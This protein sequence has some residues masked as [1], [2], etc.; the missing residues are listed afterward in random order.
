MGIDRDLRDRAEAA[1]LQR[2]NPAPG[3]F[4]PSADDYA[5]A[6]HEL[7][8]HRVE[9]EMQNDEM[10]RIE[11][12][13]VKSRDRYF[14]L[15]DLAP[16]GFITVGEQGRIL[17]A[18]SSAT[19]MLG[20]EKAA[21]I[22][23]PLT[24]FIYREDQDGYYLFRKG[25]FEAG[26]SRHCE[27]RLV[28]KDGGIFWVRIL[29]A[30]I[31][32]PLGT[33]ELLLTIGDITERKLGEEVLLKAHRANKT[34]LAEL[35]HRAKNSFSLISGLINIAAGF[36][37]EPESRKNLE[38]LVLLVQS[39]A[40]LYDLLNSSGSISE[41]R[42]DGFCARVIT[43]LARLHGSIRLETD[44]AELTLPFKTATPIGLIL[45]EL[46]TNAMKHGFPEGRKGSIRVELKSR[47]GGATLSVMDDGVGLAPDYDSRIKPGMG[48]SLIKSLTEQLGGSF[49]IETD[50]GTRCWL[51]FPILPPETPTRRTVLLVEDDALIAAAGSMVLDEFGYDVVV[52]DNGEMA[53]K[54]ATEGPRISLVLMDI[55]LG[56]GMDGLDAAAI[57]LGRRRLPLIFLSANAE[58]DVVER[59]RRISPYGYVVKNSGDFVLQTSIEMAFKLFEA[60]GRI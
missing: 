30:Q 5:I 47:K 57:I 10:H 36:S 9:L 20:M 15:Y 7:E 45:T 24:C 29:A 23:Q 44:L 41:V 16:E 38:E 19:V 42:L 46:I 32:P 31:A 50:G 2:N 6:I 22:G 18:N 48:L 52:A 43:P 1:L 21:L 56:G 13:L 55:D 39:V 3:H 26:K 60:R 37:E 59:A 51:D 8:V 11:E 35:Q 40:E 14:A 28:S 34:L 54:L 17:E 12:D 33:G 53:V 4:H 27:L 25:P 49:R 58:A